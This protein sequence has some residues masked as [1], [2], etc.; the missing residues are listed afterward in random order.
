MADL[1]EYRALTRNLLHLGGT[2]TYTPHAVTVTLDRP[3]TP[4]IARALELLTEEL[5]NTPSHI[6]G[7]DRTL[8][9]H[10]ASAHPD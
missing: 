6:P 9:Y 5:N 7:D 3:D 1:D 8:T 2:I 4:R 10:I